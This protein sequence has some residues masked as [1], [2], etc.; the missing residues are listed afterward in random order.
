MNVTTKIDWL[1]EMHGDTFLECP[2][3]EKCNEIQSLR[4]QHE[5]QQR[6]KCKQLLAK[7]GDMR[8][9]DVIYLLKQEIDR[10]TI[11]SAMQINQNS[12]EQLLDD[13]KIREY[14]VLKNDLPELETDRMNFNKSDIPLLREYVG[15]R[16]TSRT[17]SQ[18]LGVRETTVNYW[19]RKLNLIEAK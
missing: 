10:R 7:G 3:C 14:A 4:K 17:I 6:A 19:K 15:Q 8:K 18:K 11:Y 16:M 13:W 5:K 1:I 2:G 12:F 9:E